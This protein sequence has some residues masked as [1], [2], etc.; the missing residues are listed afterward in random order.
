M[1]HLSLLHSATAAIALVATVLAYARCR[2]ALHPA[3]LIG[4]LMAGGYGVWPLVLNRNG[5][6]LRFFN[7]QDLE[8][9]G[10]L[11]FVAVLAFSVSML[12]GSVS[13]HRHAS[14]P[15]LG[16]P[17]QDDRYRRKLFHLSLGLGS[18]AVAAYWY[19]IQNVG[20]FLQAYGRVKGGGWAAS[21]YIGEALLLAFP[22]VALLALSR[23]RER[24]RLQDAA[25]ALLMVSPHLLQGTF[26][27]RRG[28]LF[29]SLAVLFVAWFL[30]RGALPSLRTGVLA[31]STMMLAVVLVSS[32]RQEV[33]IG[34]QGSVDLSRTLEIV[35]PDALTVGNEYVMGV[36]TVLTSEHHGDY[37]W[38]YRYFVTYFIRPIPKQI[39]PSKY[40]DVGATWIDLNTHENE[41]RYLEAVGLIPVAGA[42]SGVV[43]DLYAEFA[44][45]I[46][47]AI[48]VLGWFYAWLWAKHRLRSGIWSV[49]YIELIILSIY[50]PVQSLSAV[51]HRFVFMS[52]FTTLAWR[53][54]IGRTRS[55]R[56]EPGPS[57]R[58]TRPL[59]VPGR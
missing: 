40:E 2:D 45:G 50:L 57:D 27:G 18:I 21:G 13:P 33:Y 4:P 12:G 44:W 14:A 16:A 17:L 42:S 3:V 37:Y 11:Y 38:G 6:L 58:W 1:S 25:L 10:F 36:A 53:Y 5:D 39:W 32:Q 41:A 26:G 31:V 20:G 54:W 51:L 29:L 59:P 19:M 22:A 23:F 52:V 35:N 24:I 34:S 8:K 47:P 46:L 15:D 30:A 55:F 49:L 56:P 43:A 28:P 7:L 9:V 48:M